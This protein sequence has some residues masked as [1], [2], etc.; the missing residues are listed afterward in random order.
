MKANP[1]ISVIVPMY[2][3]EEYIVPCVTSILNQTMNAQDFEIILIDDCSTDTTYE[4]C[5]KLYGDNN[6]VKILSHDVNKGL[7]GV[8]NTGIEEAR[9]KYIYFIDSNDLILPDALET[10]YKAAEESNADVVHSSRWYQ[11]DDVD[12]RNGALDKAFV[13]TDLNPQPGFLTENVLDRVF[14][15]WSQGELAVTVWL[16]L[17]RRKFLIENDLKFAEI[18]S[19]DVP[20]SLLDI[21]FAKRYLK[22]PELLYV[23]RKRP[24]AITTTPHSD[25]KHLSKVVS[26]FIVGTKYLDDNI[27]RLPPFDRNKRLREQVLYM[28]LG[29]VITSFA[30][31]RYDEVGD[32]PDEFDKAVETA[33]EKFFGENSFF[34]KYLFHTYNW[35]MVRNGNKN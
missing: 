7:G 28:Y 3:V 34:V 13:Y 25:M 23:Y 27:K 1:I 17:Y 9:G 19:E 26:S 16:N 15:S 32:I 18:I 20:F 31:E 24:N 14:K 11:I 12:L 6:R 33:L 21:A 4:I 2:N 8:R 22:I 30:K 10:L 5:S 29:K 35:L